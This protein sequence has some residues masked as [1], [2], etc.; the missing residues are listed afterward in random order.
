MNWRHFAWAM[1]GGL[2]FSA[3]LQRATRAAEPAASEGTI[4]YRNDFELEPGSTF[5]E[6]TSSA[7]VYTS[8][9]NPPGSGKLDA[10][11]VTN[12]ASPQGNR[13]FLGEFGGPRLDPTARTRVQQSVR[14]TLDKLPLHAS[15][16]VACDLL[17]LKSWD[18]SSP[19]YGPD[20]WKLSVLDGPMLLDTTF[21]NNPKLETDGSSQDYPESASRPQSGAAAVNSLGYDFFGDSIYRLN[22]TFP[23]AADKLVLEFSGDL[24]EGKGAKDESWG[25]D[26]VTVSV[27]SK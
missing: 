25:L 9:F 23:H 13:R 18:G 6:W 16:A 26:N 19:R 2:I 15:V 5:P 3:M 14:L 11:P 4:V 7:I 20:R 1:A 24:F 8:Q 17:V 22:F 12:V 27:Q 21:S 10:P